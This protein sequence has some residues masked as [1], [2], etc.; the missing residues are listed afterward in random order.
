LTRVAVIIH[1]RLGTWARQLR[2]RLH[3]QPVRWFETR[4]AAD[5]ERVLTG[6]AHPVVLV[7]LGNQ[8]VSDLAV[9]GLVLHRVSDARV[10]VVD[11]HARHHVLTLAREL[12]ATHVVSGFVPPPIV[13]ELLA[14]WIALARRA[15][16]GA[17]W[18][19]PPV[20]DARSDPWGWLPDILH[21][22]AGDDITGIKPEAPQL[23][24]SCW[25]LVGSGRVDWG[26]LDPE[27]L[28]SLL[29][30]TRKG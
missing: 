29:E 25:P 1:E 24:A 26:C 30:T 4:S 12:G 14:H 6:L 11:S 20:L 16:E 2:P 21:Q 13:A 3:E 22:R 23:I 27:S 28:D 7:D 15:L 19:A 5:L 8:P 18:F 17:G 10:L 9:L